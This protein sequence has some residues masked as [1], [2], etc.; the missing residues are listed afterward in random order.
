[1]CSNW[2]WVKSFPPP[3]WRRCILLQAQVSRRVSSCSYKDHIQRSWVCQSMIS[4]SMVSHLRTM[5]LPLSYQAR[6]LFNSG[7]KTTRCGH[8]YVHVYVAVATAGDRSNLHRCDRRPQPRLKILCHHG[9]Y[10]DDTSSQDQ[11]RLTTVL[12]RLVHRVSWTQLKR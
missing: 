10:G 7:W 2:P 3:S 8:V 4:A 11:R 12:H 1:M 6:P 9:W 5:S